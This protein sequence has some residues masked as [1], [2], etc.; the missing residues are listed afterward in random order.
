MKYFTETLLE[1]SFYNKENLDYFNAFLREK[2]LLRY[3]L[4][5][6][7]VRP[8]EYQAIRMET[9]GRFD[10]KHLF[11][12]ESTTPEQKETN[13]L[14]FSQLLTTLQKCN[15]LDNDSLHRR[16]YWA[17]YKFLYHLF[18]EIYNSPNKHADEDCRYLKY[19]IFVMSLKVD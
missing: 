10:G 2:S 14:F 6:P 13:R 15:I 12:P 3:L 1:Y 19:Y 5:P 18:Y 17:N 16:A 9:E 8:E 4:T 11:L 7:P